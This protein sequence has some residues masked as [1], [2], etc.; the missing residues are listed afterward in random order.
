LARARRHR[1]LHGGRGLGLGWACSDFAER[2]A[3]LRSRVWSCSLTGKGSLT[4]EEAL[5]SEQGSKRLLDKFPATHERVVLQRVQNNTARVDELVT[6]IYREYLESF[7]VGEDV[8]ALLPGTG[9]TRDGIV[10]AVHPATEREPRSYDVKLRLDPA[11]GPSQTLTVRETEL[12]RKRPP[13]TKVVLR[14]WIIESASFT[15]FGK[16][17]GGVWEVKPWLAAQHQLEAS[18]AE[19]LA[20][21]A[22]RKR[23]GGTS[24]APRGKRS[25]HANATGG[26]SQAVELSDETNAWLDEVGRKVGVREGTLRHMC[27]TIL[28]EGGEDGMTVTDLAARIRDRGLRDLGDDRAAYSK[29]YT[30]L[31]T[32]WLFT[33]IGRGTFALR[34]L[35]EPEQ[36]RRTL[37]QK[38]EED[39]A[40]AEEKEKARAAPPSGG[41]DAGCRGSRTFNARVN[42]AVSKAQAVVTKFSSR[43]EMLEQSYE[44][45]QKAAE[46][47]LNAKPQKYEAPNHLRADLVPEKFNGD[48]SDRKAILA[49]RKAV[50]QERTRRTVELERWAKE[51][52]AEDKKARDTVRMGVAQAKS[53]VFKAQSLLKKAQI[54]LLKAESM[55]ASG[56]ERESLRRAARGDQLTRKQVDRIRAIEER[57]REKMEARERKRKEREEEKRRREQAKIDAKRYPIDDLLLQEELEMK[58]KVEGTAV[59]APLKCAPPLSDSEKVVLPSAMAVVEFIAS[60]GKTVGISG[61]TLKD[62]LAMLFAPGPDLAGLFQQVLAIVLD[63]AVSHPSGMR[64]I[65]RWRQALRSSWA[66]AAWP[67]VL[68][69]YIMCKGPTRCSEEVWHAAEY[70]K[71]GSFDNVTPGQL[72]ALLEHI[73]EDMLDTEE[74]RGEMEGRL[75]ALHE[76]TVERRQARID[77]RKAMK[78]FEDADKEKR[79]QERE[80]KRE[81]KK[82]A[83]ARAAARDGEDVE[84]SEDEEE[85]DDDD[86]EEEEEVPCFEIPADKL[87]FQGNAADRK[88]VLAHRKWVEVETA[89]LNRERHQWEK[90]RRKKQMEEAAERNA[91]RLAREREEVQYEKKMDSFDR[92]LAR[93]AIRAQHLGLDRNFN[94]YWW[95]LASQRA[96]VFVETEEGRWGKF[97]TLEDLAEFVQALDS[98]GVR[99]RALLGEFEDRF[100]TIQ[101]CMKR[102]GMTADKSKSEPKKVEG[103][104]PMRVSSRVARVGSAGGL[105]VI[106]SADG[107][108]LTIAE[109]GMKSMACGLL[110]LAKAADCKGV[111]KEGGWKNLIRS[112]READSLPIGEA[113][114]L[115]RAAMLEL[116]ELLYHATMPEEE[117]K[118]KA[119][120]SDGETREVGPPEEAQR[121][122]RCQCGGVLATFDPETFMFRVGNSTGD[123]AR[124]L[125]GPRLERLGGKESQKKWRQSVRVLEG[126]YA[127]RTIGEFIDG[128]DLHPVTGAP[129]DV[130]DDE[131]APRPWYE[132]MEASSSDE[133]VDP[134]RLELY[135]RRWREERARMLW[136]SAREHK[137]WR[138]GVEDSASIQSLSYHAAVL[139]DRFVVSSAALA[140]VGR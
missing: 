133:E 95:G 25:A 65:R 30:V 71:S 37:Q 87:V 114:D 134:R 84:N 115:F 23:V 58:S 79:R 35:V 52:K 119:Q 60:F 64:R 100:F 45:A 2:L 41:V 137:A 53:E 97:A 129:D 38:E 28:R 103:A 68:R 70:L 24:D 40:K 126:K 1:R 3:L 128:R 15:D 112:L 39:A 113:L 8:Q 139:D 31:N 75:E 72:A 91:D 110:R 94:R 5:Q 131:K 4:Y 11:V 42:S 29:V 136:W 36:V 50:E 56:E 14:R 59:P 118:E 61:V 76:I 34:A 74:I 43:L 81:A 101:N 88:E 120:L 32:E 10:T 105:G 127:G 47:I 19:E 125:N 80:A 98:R 7:L 96:D 93:I 22:K 132:H 122:V 99:E 106:L 63:K 62:L 48:Y 21:G 26:F 33:R 109:Q 111:P 130:S 51:R 92:E 17:K 12:T 18:R 6:S 46:P 67:E 89:R 57:K 124:I 77:H 138:E 73:T 27:L 9:Q 69:R 123:S 140:R 90:D 54:T 66:S 83:A 49:H 121:P 135:A 20:A 13:F 117:E 16:G 78:V 55:R 116:D 85:D 107:R 104:A 82:K 44:E 86:V 102:A 108:V